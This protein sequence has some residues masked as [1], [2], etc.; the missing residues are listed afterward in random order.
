MILQAAHLSLTR[1]GRTLINDANFLIQPYDRIGLVGRNGAGKSTLLQVLAGLVKPDA[2]TIN[3]NKRATIGYMPQEQVMTSSKPVMEEVLSAHPYHPIEQRIAAIEQQLTIES[4]E[5]L[6][7]ELQELHAALEVHHIPDILQ[8]AKNIVQGLGFSAQQLAMTVDSLSVGWKMR[9]VLAQLLLKN[10]DFYLFDEPTNHLDI[11]TQEWFLQF[12]AKSSFGFM[13]VSH[14]KAFLDKLCTEIYEIELGKLTPYTGNYSQYLEQKEEE[15][16]VLRQKY[17]LQQREI[18]RK[19]ET[20]ERFRASA[21]KAK[22]AQ[23][24]I[25]EL[26]RIE[27]ITLPP[28]LSSVAF[29]FKL[30]ARSGEVTLQVKNLRQAFGNKVIFDHVSFELKRGSK[31]AIVAANGVGKTTLLRTIIGGLPQHGIVEW[32]H[33]VSLAVFEQESTGLPGDM[34]IMDYLL[35]HTTNKTD[36]QIRSLLGAFLFSGDTVQKKLKVLSGGE[37]NRVKM[38]QVLLQDANVLLL[39]EPTNHLDIDSKERL[40][41]A[42]QSYPGTILFVSHDRDFVNRLANHILE[43]TPHGVH[44][45][46]GNYDQYLYYREAQ[47]QQTTSSPTTAKTSISHKQEKPTHNHYEM[48]KESRKLEQRIQKLEQEIITLHAELANHEY[49]SSEFTR[50]MTHVRDKE[51]QLKES[52][53]RWDELVEKILE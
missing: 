19:K 5:A 44:Q 20:I 41:G 35:T 48:S 43:L 45:Y 51:K 52:Q 22:M 30:P 6:L 2:G 31:T 7:N 53:Y 42:L 11:V 13:L 9:V 1:G 25:K 49:G 40:L 29:S 38:C 21:S 32:G 47:I 28:S 50:I 26:E 8:Q 3:I 14:D 15:L 37:K 39:D 36:A 10:A 33:N 27:L 23:S 12:L 18:A 16:V 17:E 24:M 4:N 46:E 34:T